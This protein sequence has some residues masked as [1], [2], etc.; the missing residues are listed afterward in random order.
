MSAKLPSS[1]I[2]YVDF[3]SRNPIECGTKGCSICKESEEHDVTFFGDVSATDP[4]N[5]GDLPHITM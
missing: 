1:L 3:T 5:T 2:E 4:E